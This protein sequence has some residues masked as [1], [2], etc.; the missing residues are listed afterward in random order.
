[1]NNKTALFFLI[2]LLAL[3]LVQAR[4]F[5]YADETDYRNNVN[6]ALSRPFDGVDAD[7]VGDFDR[8][9][10][11]S[12]DDHN[13]FA[14]A[15]SYDSYEPLTARTASRD[16]L[17]RLRRADQLRLVD[18]NP[19]DSLDRDDLDGY[20]DWGCYTL[21]DYNSYAAENPYDNRRVVDFTHFDDLYEVKKIG[22]YRYNNF[23]TVPDDFAKFNLQYTRRPAPF[24]E[25]YD[26]R[27]SPYPLYGY[28]VARREDY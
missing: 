21:G 17:S 11:I 28:G 18:E 14:N 5:Y 24:Y 15:D 20:D 12:L 4:V 8:Y 23:Y 3:P 1:M 22:K 19:Y 25:P 7:D 6:Y 13:A 9:S 2:A 16:D 26:Y 10:C 27:T